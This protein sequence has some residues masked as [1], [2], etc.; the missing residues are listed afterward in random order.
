MIHKHTVKV[1][2]FV[3]Y[4]EILPVAIENATRKL[5]EWYAD[6]QALCYSDGRSIWQMSAST[7][8]RHRF[9]GA[10]EYEYIISVFD[11]RIE[12]EQ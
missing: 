5:N 2:T 3:G 12:F 9:T 10:G 8:H 11:T 4:D 6:Q 7:I 1:L